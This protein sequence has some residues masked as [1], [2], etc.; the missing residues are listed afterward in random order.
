[1][2]DFVDMYCAMPT[3]GLVEQDQNIGALLRDHSIDAD[4]HITF[5]EF[6]VLMLRI[7]SR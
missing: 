6:C 5:N 4:G 7:A 1:M 3:H 2:Q